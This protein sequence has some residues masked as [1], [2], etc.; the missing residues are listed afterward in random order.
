MVRNLAAMLVVLTA[1]CASSR[2]PETRPLVGTGGEA[3]ISQMLEA[4]LEADARGDAADSL[5]APYAVVIADGRVRRTR[6]RFAGVG[7]EE[8][9]VAITNT[10]VQARTGAAWGDVEYRWV[11]ARSNSIRVGRAS[12]VLTP[13]GERQSWWIVQLHSSTVR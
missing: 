9:E 3:E 10:R 6:P 12:Y 7:G 13:A 4:A 2:I 1:A 5:Y 11:A 8:G